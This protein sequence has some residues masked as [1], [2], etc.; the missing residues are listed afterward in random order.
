MSA[1]NFLTLGGGLNGN[2]DL[3]LGFHDGIIPDTPIIRDSNDG[4]SM[5]PTKGY[6][7]AMN[8]DDTLTVVV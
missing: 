4:L 3:L 6:W 2:W 5:Y 7:I 8:S 1:R